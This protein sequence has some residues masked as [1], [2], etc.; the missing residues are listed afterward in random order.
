MVFP[1]PLCRPFA[2]SPAAHSK[3]VRMSSPPSSVRENSSLQ[4]TELRAGNSRPYRGDSRA[5]ATTGSRRVGG[6]SV[7]GSRL[8]TAAWQ[9]S[10]FPSRSR[11]LTC[12]DPAGQ[13]RPEAD[14]DLRFRHP[15]ACGHLAPVVG[16]G[17]SGNA[18][19]G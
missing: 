17:P 11:S 2:A 8:P 7:L 15:D 19:S 6:N 13:E 4:K 9:S 12:D 14:E 5:E 10:T 1:S 16:R 3:K 18:G